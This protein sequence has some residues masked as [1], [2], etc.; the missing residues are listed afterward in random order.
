L[1]KTFLQFGERPAYSNKPAQYAIPARKKT[2]RKALLF[3]HAFLG[4][5]ADDKF[6]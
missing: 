5:A 2:I 1:L 3:L 6:P 4:G